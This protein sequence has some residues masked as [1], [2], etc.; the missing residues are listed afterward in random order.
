M[1]NLSRVIDYHMVTIAQ[2]I[3]ILAKLYILDLFNLLSYPNDSILK[4]DCQ[5]ILT[6]FF[7][8][9]ILLLYEQ[10]TI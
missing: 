3:V 5:N 2:S 6:I 10:N 1:N 7:L 8:F 4:K 9:D